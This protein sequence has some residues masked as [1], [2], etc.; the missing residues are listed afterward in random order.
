M[1]EKLKISKSKT[2]LF[3]IFTIVVVFTI[4]NFICGLI[5]Q[6]RYIALD[7]LTPQ[8]AQ[9]TYGYFAPNQNKIILFPGIN[10]YKVTINNLGLRIVSPV[11]Q[12]PKSLE[13]IKTKNRILCVGDSETFGNGVNDEDTFPYQLQSLIKTEGKDAVVFNAG[14]GGATIT[15]YLEYLKVKGLTLNPSVV[16]VQFFDNDIQNLTDWKESKYDEMIEKSAFSFERQFKLMNFM[17]IFRKME[18]NARWKRWIRKTA[19]P[20]VREILKTDSKDKDDNIYY[21]STLFGN[22]NTDPL[23]DELKPSWDK[24]FADLTAIHELLR[25][26]NVELIFTIY[27]SVCTLFDCG[28]KNYQEIL[29]EYLKKNQIPYVDMREKLLPEREQF[30]KLYINL[31]RDYHMS[32]YSKGIEAKEVYKLIKDKI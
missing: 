4:I 2:I 12:E 3:S 14:I 21:S 28:K 13:E 9:K 16:V 31:P 11:K 10:D 18:L 30:L 1:S 23:N 26:K 15:D 19:D 17:R 8:E 6:N 32:P 29:V 5:V 7:P 20:R 24:F 22:I 25:S 27:P